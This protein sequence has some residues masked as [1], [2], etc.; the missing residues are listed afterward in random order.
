MFSLMLMIW[1]PLT[2]AYKKLS[3]HPSFRFSTGIYND[4]VGFY[5]DSSDDNDSKLLYLINGG[6]FGAYIYSNRLDSWKEIEF[7]VKS[8]DPCTW[9]VPTWSPATFW[10]QCLYFVVTS[11]TFEWIVCFD[12]KTGT[13]RKIQFPHV[14]CDAGEYCGSLVVLNGCLHLHVCTA[15]G[16]DWLAVF[17]QE[18]SSVRKLNAEDFRRYQNLCYQSW[19]YG[20]VETLVSPNP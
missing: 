9:S 12:V 4:V 16:G 14:P 8:L 20:Y 13:F 10:G 19:E 15:S 17:D 11:R 3:S 5:K 7:S 1:N 2:G 6:D 18:K